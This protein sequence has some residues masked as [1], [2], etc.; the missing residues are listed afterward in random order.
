M[1]S[2]KAHIPVSESFGFNDFLRASTG[3]K[4]FPQMIFS[5]WEVMSG[6]DPLDPDTK[7]GGVVEAIRVRK[8]IKAEVP[9]LDRYL[10]KL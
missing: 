8:G 5:H 10:D 4:A 7:L 9:P 3:G 6:G 2:L 1:M